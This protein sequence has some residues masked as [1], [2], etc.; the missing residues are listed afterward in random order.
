MFQCLLLSGNN[1]HTLDVPEVIANYRKCHEE[2]NLDK[3]ANLYI[4]DHTH[5]AH[6][7]DI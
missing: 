7:D 3:N 2:Y 6:S 1:A 5:L 4:V